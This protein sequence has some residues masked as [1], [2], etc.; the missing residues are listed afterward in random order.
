MTEKTLYYSQPSSGCRLCLRC[1]GSDADGFGSVGLERTTNVMSCV[2][3]M[4]QYCWEKKEEPKTKKTTKRS[5][6]LLTYSI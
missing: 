6:Q 5:R 4:Q 3:H 1:S 2:P